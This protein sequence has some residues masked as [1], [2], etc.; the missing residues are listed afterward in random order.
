M[1]RKINN[2]RSQ[3]NP[4]QYGER[5]LIYAPLNKDIRKII[6]DKRA[7]GNKSVESSDKNSQNDIETNDI[8]LEKYSHNQGKTTL[9]TTP[10]K[11]TKNSVTY[12]KKTQ[13]YDPSKDFLYINYNNYTFQEN[14]T[15]INNYPISNSISFARKVP[16]PNFNSP[17][18]YIYNS[19]KRNIKT[20]KSL[21]ITYRKK[22][23]N[24][25]SVERGKKIKSIKDHHRLK[26]D[27][28]E[29]IQSIRNTNVAS[30]GRQQKIFKKRSSTAFKDD[31]PMDYSSDEN[32]N[33]EKENDRKII[34][35]KIPIEQ[36]KKNRNIRAIKIQSFWRGNRIR[37]LVDY[38]K[39]LLKFNR[40]LKD[41]F[42]EHTEKYLFDFMEKVSKLKKKTTLKKGK[43]IASKKKLKK[44]P[45][46]KDLKIQK[47]IFFS[48]EI[49]E[50]SLYYKR[51]L[52][53]L[54]IEKKYKKL[55]KKHETLLKNY[56]MKNDELR[57]CYEKLSQS[58][59]NRQPMNMLYYSSVKKQN[60]KNIPISN[61]FNSLHRFGLSPLQDKDSIRANKKRDDMMYSFEEKR[62]DNS[63]FC[64]NNDSRVE[65]YLNK[66]YVSI[67]LKIVHAN[68][69]YIGYLNDN[70]L[71]K[72][73]EKFRNK[74]NIP[75][76]NDKKKKICIKKELIVPET[77]VKQDNKVL[78]VKTDYFRF[79]DNNEMVKESFE[80]IS[81]ISG[82]DDNTLKESNINQFEILP[83]E[84]KNDITNNN[85]CKMRR[86]KI[87]NMNKKDKDS[88]KDLLL[89]KGLFKLEKIMSKMN[90]KK[91]FDDFVNIISKYQKENSKELYLFNCNNIE[92]L[93]KKINN[94]DNLK[95]QKKNYENEK[96]PIFGVDH[97]ITRNINKSNIKSVEKPNLIITKNI[98]F[99]L[100]S[101]KLYNSK[102]NKN[103]LNN[104]GNKEFITKNIPISNKFN[105]GKL[106][107]NRIIKNFRI[108]KRKPSLPIITKI[109][110]N[111]L[112]INKNITENINKYI[113]NK[114]SQTFNIKPHKREL[115]ITKIIEN[116]NIK[117][118]NDFFKSNLVINKIIN[119]SIIDNQE[120]KTAKKCIKKNKKIHKTNEKE[121]SND[122]ICDKELLIQ[123]D[124]LLIMEAV[125][126]FNII[127]NNKNDN[128][129]IFKNSD[130]LNIKNNEA[131]TSINSRFNNKFNVHD[132]AITKII[133]NYFIKNKNMQNQ[134][135]QNNGNK[136]LVENELRITKIISNFKIKNIYT[137]NFVI[138]KNIDNLNIKANSN[139]FVITKVLNSYF[140]GNNR[141]YNINEERTQN[142][143][144]EQT[145]QIYKNN[146][147]IL[148]ITRIINNF[149]LNDS[150][151]WNYLIAMDFNKKSV[152]TKKIDLVINKK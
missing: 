3:P 96:F 112:F 141:Y 29:N 131:N 59:N 130:K 97:V 152:I 115:I 27:D 117:K 55:L 4:V 78:K 68:K 56:S 51:Y 9:D 11:H 57:E 66:S 76:S 32:N 2:R 124:Y 80:K 62:K 125:S 150:K 1:K 31:V 8:P 121:I 138:T 72:H 110:E 113:I 41:I 120:N 39:D 74:N 84:I 34:N 30:R 129:L 75:V 143:N 71:N 123:K 135:D 140:I 17:K 103:Y 44:V 42:T 86:Y 119:D 77:Q 15:D 63:L 111:N 54:K 20:D 13:N 139:D 116:F 151:K 45:K 10:T 14:S 28:F 25:L 60:L 50:N 7:Q 106:V 91:H 6:A 108:L 36:L 47:E 85:I 61:N 40:I 118:C 35:K 98:I 90:S 109:Y 94:E 107:I 102:N 114:N 46:P 58:N 104:D 16:D 21:N 64:D 48:Y 100:K 73:R 142:I 82:F 128:N 65:N 12:I 95:N 83:Q 87:R 70:K 146:N 53:L 145:K 22:I 144:E 69:I 126:K 92:I 18:I 23:V 26:T 93:G 122:N 148:R 43:K 136:K 81:T 5:D 49:D 89:V 147:D 134:I 52:N 101:K 24:P 37:Q 132:F 127:Q 38:Y 88:K 105:D 19:N 33:F 67:P 133:N 137:N 149:S 79:N 99:N